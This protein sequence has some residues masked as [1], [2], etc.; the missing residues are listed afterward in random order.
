MK[1]TNYFLLLFILVSL[2]GCK[3]NK[4]DVDVSDV[5]VDLEI[6]RFDEHLFTTTSDDIYY[7][8]PKMQET[9]GD[10]FLIYNSQIIGV[11][12][13]EQKEY[14]SNL[15]NFMNYCDQAK[16]YSEVVAV[17]P[18]NNTF[19]EDK[20][21]FA[22]K[23]YKF[24]FPNKK[25]P[26]IITCISGFNVSVFTGTDYIGISLD[27]YLGA[28]FDGYKDM[29]ENYLT[30]RM[31]KEMLPVDVMKSLSIAEFPYND[32]LNTVLT[33]SIYEG[34]IQ[35]FL[36]AMLPETND[37][38]KWGYTNEQLGWANK[39][40]KKI[41]D[42]MVDDKLLFSNKTMD[43]TTFTGESPFTTPLNNNSAPRAGSFIGYKIVQS[44]MKNNPE[45]SLSDLMNETDYMKI[46][47][48]SFY[49]P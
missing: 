32:S 2:F 37:S 19:I 10:F 49:N 35:Y 28:S 46:Y 26:K 45:I 20:L 33:S 29:F 41:W 48:L 38:L 4:F 25:I 8:I 11:G 5:N 42:F 27:K 30:R 43:I 47:N 21:T 14:F 13:P 12:F 22:F 17:F 39:Y 24:Y 23:H 18:H 9:Y 34:R 31:H 44:Y 36:D 40:E 6:Y 7:E 15:F 1:N 3:E 16:L